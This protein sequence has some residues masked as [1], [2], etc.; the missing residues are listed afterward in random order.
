V[1]ERGS[2]FRCRDS[3]AEDNVSAR[4]VGA[5]E[6]RAAARRP[7]A[8]RLRRGHA[9]RGEL[10]DPIH[11]RPHLRRAVEPVARRVEPLAL[12]GEGPDGPDRVAAGDERADVRAAA[13][14]LGEHL[15]PAVEPDWQAASIQG[16]AVP[17]VDDRAAPGGDDAT[18]RWLGV[19]RPEVLDR[20]P[21]HRPECGLALLGEDLRDLPAGS[22]LDR[23]VEIDV[24][25]VVAMG[26]PPPDGA[27]AA[28]WQPDEND[29]HRI[30]RPRQ[31]PP[32]RRLRQR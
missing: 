13:K 11:E 26:E 10:V 30:S 19:W 18:D 14:A 9:T 32:R 17:R 1:A 16:P 24:R 4:R 25:R 15:R 28:A 31:S 22:P 27:L 3:L 29:V 23:L 7:I 12:P 8:T 6:H 5:E 20:R 21:F 2:H